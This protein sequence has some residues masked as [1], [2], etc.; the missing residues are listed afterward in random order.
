MFLLSACISHG[1]HIFYTFVINNNV[2]NVVTLGISR[3]NIVMDRINESAA[4]SIVSFNTETQNTDQTVFSLKTNDNF[5][6]L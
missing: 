5:T 2:F 6:R 3:R 4:I 1:I